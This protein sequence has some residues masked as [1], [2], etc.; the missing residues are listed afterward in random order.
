MY[1]GTMQWI[2]SRIVRLLVACVMLSGCDRTFGR[3]AC[4]MEHEV[5][6]ASTNGVPGEVSVV[7]EDP[8]TYL[9]VWSAD[10]ETRA[11]RFNRKGSLI[12][13]PRTIP[14]QRAVGPL[15]GFAARVSSEIAEGEGRKTF[16]P[17]R[18]RASINA[19][20]I[21]AVSLG[22][23]RVAVVLVE[24]SK[25]GIAGGAYLA[26]LDEAGETTHLI[27]LGSA[28]EY[29][30]R[31]VV[32]RSDGD[33]IVAWHDGMLGVSKIR[34]AAIDAE[35]FEVKNQVALG[36]DG[37]VAAPSLAAKDGLITLAWSETASKQGRGGE[38]RDVVGGGLSAV[39]IA[40]L[41]R[42]L[43]LSGKQTLAT[44]R[45]VNPSPRLAVSEEGIAL[46][47]RD[48][49]DGDDTPE[50]H[51]IP[52]APNGTKRGDRQRIS[53]AD[54]YKGPAL[55]ADADGFI[56]ATVRSFQRN[57]LIGLNRMDRMG[58][59][60]GGEFQVYADK[61]DFI[62]VDITENRGEVMIVYAED[63]QDKGRILAGAVVCAERE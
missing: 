31:I 56:G 39:N 12:D 51:F 43:A 4:R 5:L 52:L 60:R 54:G 13:R 34:V 59:K 32:A 25:S 19:A 20:D 35:T 61:T 11:V 30:E 15:R 42:R 38:G 17:E 33:L 58:H 62:R 49:E 48:D 63:R 14:R 44:S 10:G 47:Y 50:Y 1:C 27:Y 3:Q 8:G 21:D 46:V 57:L 37:V 16:W 9:A 29:A 26:V 24:Q 2:G 6:L 36:G 23:G 22:G 41:S 55:V 45:F 7:A 28:G 18:K 40:V 53:T